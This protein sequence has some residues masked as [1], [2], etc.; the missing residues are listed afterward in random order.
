MLHVMQAFVA[1]S[2]SQHPHPRTTN[3]KAK[4][5]ARR[6][7]P[8]THAAT[9]S[10]RHPPKQLSRW[11]WTMLRIRVRR[12]SIM[13]TIREPTQMLP[14]EGPAARARA[15]RTVFNVFVFWCGEC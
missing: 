3:T 14:S 12:P 4:R 10:R 15:G 7:A 13:E 2:P 11:D 6:K 9:Q 5:F 8:S 1:P